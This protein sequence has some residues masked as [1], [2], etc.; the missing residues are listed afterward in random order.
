MT[1][2]VLLSAD[3]R[4]HQIGI[5]ARDYAYRI[6][7]QPLGGSVKR[8]FD[9]VVASIAL[10]FLAPVLLLVA[11]LVVVDSRGTIL[12]RQRRSGFRGKQFSV[13]KFRTMRADV[14]KGPVAQ[15]KRVDSRVTGVGRILRR[16]SVDELPQ[17]LNVLR[18][19]MSLV[20]PRPHAVSHD[21]DFCSADERYTR[22]FLARPG[23][24][25]L[26]QVSGCRGP[27]ETPTK[28]RERLRHDLDYVDNWSIGLDLAI[29][30]K[31]VCVVLRDRNA[32]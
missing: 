30:W 29:M 18:G 6:A 2:H 1:V 15:A 10:L 21:Y 14:C 16:T 8:F 5:P 7:P 22:R 3:A 13:F 32:F 27:T 26:A 20:G 25:G 28:V 19:E 24:T 23:V 9:I 4:G 12:F 17:L 31:T 11:A